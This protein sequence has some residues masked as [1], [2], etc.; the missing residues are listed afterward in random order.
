MGFRDR[1][2]R[3]LGQDS[4]VDAPGSTGRVWT[5]NLPVSFDNGTGAAAASG[6]LFGRG[7]SADPVTTSTASAK[8]IEFRCETTAATGD[9]RLLY[10]RY[11]IGGAAG[12]ETLRAL[13][14]VNANTSTAHGAHLS[15]GFVATAGGS[16]CSGLG[17]A[18]RGTLHI[19]NV[20]SWAPAGTYA[21]GMFEI[22]SD[23]SS[24]NP[25]GMTELSVLQL[26]NSGDATGAADIDDQAF[27]I[28]VQGFTAANEAADDVWINTITA[29]TINAACTEALK[30]KVG[31]NTR[32][33]PIATATA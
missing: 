8:F 12:G 24:S 7:T 25:S 28:S 3:A 11:A 1:V 22:Y 13:T 30:I 32:Y 31:A 14:M 23:G 15:L 19:P 10:M 5:F 27:L 16:E 20:A 2:Q 29:A 6:L 17:V 33:I 9:N 26:S 18:V 21:A 4:G